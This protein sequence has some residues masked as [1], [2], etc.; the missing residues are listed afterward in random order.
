M[1]DEV[2]KRLGPTL[3][4]GQEVREQGRQR[5]H[6]SIRAPEE[7]PRSPLPAGAR[8]AG[9]AVPSRETPVFI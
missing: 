7:P 4:L 2:I 1:R 8:Q 5:P 3:S 6:I 9:S